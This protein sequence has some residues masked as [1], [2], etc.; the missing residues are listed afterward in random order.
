VAPAA[1]AASASA[2]AAAAAGGLAVR[3]QLPFVAPAGLTKP[4]PLDLA[5]ALKQIFEVPFSPAAAAWPL[6]LLLLNLLLLLLLLQVALR[7]VCSCRL[8]PLQAPP[9]RPH[10]TWQ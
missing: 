10:W 1:A 8:W 6:L 7:C 4:S 9:S 5:A 2:A 3:V